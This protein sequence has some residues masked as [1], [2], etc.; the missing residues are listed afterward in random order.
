MPMFT[1]LFREARVKFSY[2]LESARGGV[3]RLMGILRDYLLDIEQGRAVRP[4]LV[5][6]VRD[7]NCI[8]YRR[9][10]NEVMRHVPKDIS[11][12]VCALIPD[13]HI[14][15]WAM[16]DPRAFKEVVGTGCQLP[17]LKCGK[18]EYKRL[19]RDTFRALGVNYALGGLEVAGP[20]GK[21][22][23]ISVNGLHDESFNSAISNVRAQLAR[24]RAEG[25]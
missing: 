11:N 19:L 6:V 1:R 21:S 13:P 25:Q 10:Q 7:G 9:R 5:I 8:G 22:M 23:D 18:N 14:E 15:R 16:I 2:R 12:L 20:I 4:D 17:N 24:I 3:P